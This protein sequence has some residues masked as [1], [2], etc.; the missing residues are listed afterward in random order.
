[1]HWIKRL[2]REYRRKDGGTGISRYGLA[3]MV[4]ERKVGGRNVGCSGLLIDIL[5]H[6]GI[7]HPA[8]A[9]VITLVC[10]GTAENWNSIVHEDYRGQWKPGQKINFK[11]RFE[12]EA[13]EFSIH[14][15]QAKK[16]P[17]EKKPADKPKC[18]EMNVD[19]CKPVVQ[20]CTHG[21]EIMRFASMTEAAAHAKVPISSVSQ[22]CNKNI[23][24]R[25]DEFKLAK[26]TWRFAEEWDAM[27]EKQRAEE[28]KRARKPARKKG[29]A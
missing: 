15:E 19:K 18:T 13:E 21:M 4:R 25:T 24:E 2:R 3:K 29:T 7:T 12:D 27:D 23:S 5:E 6:G 1:M 20:I 26:C 17:A 22:R 16:K 14:P 28:V 11:P 9:A 10:G 8:I